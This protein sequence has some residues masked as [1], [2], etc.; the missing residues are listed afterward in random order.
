MSFL[1]PLLLA[2]LPLCGLPILIHLINQRRFQTVEWGAM[3]FLLEANRMAR[4]H[5]RIRRWL[6]LACRTLAI[7][8]LIFVISRPLAS[9]WIGLAGGS[10]SDTTI[11]LL[12]RSPSM[13]QR[14]ALAHASKLETGISQLSQAL[15][16]V[17]SKRWILIDSATL[18]SQELESPQMLSRT[19][20]ANAVSKSAH[21]PTLIQAAHDYIQENRSGQTEIWIL[22]DLQANDWDAENGRWKTLRDSFLQ[23]QQAVRFHLLAYPEAAAANVGVRVTSIERQQTGDTAQLLLSIILTA[24]PDAKSTEIPLRFDIQGVR[25]EHVVQ[26]EGPQLE[27]RN[28]AIPIDPELKQGHGRVTIP[29]DAYPTDDEYYFVFSEPMPRRAI[30]V[31]D[32]EDVPRP[33]RLA[34]A[35]SPDPNTFNEVEVVRPAQIAALNLGDVALLVWQAPL[36]QGGDATR[37]ESFVASGGQVIFLPPELPTADTLFG[38]GWTDWHETETSLAIENWRSDEDLLVRTQSGQS[39]PVGQLQIHRFCGLT[40][41]FTKLAWLKDGSPLLARVPTGKGGVWFLTT[42]IQPRDSSLAIDGVV[43]YAMLQ[44]AIANGAAARGNTQNVVAGILPKETTLNWKQLEGAGT[45]LSSDYADIAGVYSAGDRIVAINRSEQEDNPATLPLEKVDK[46]FE[47]LRFDRVS[48]SAGEFSALARE[49]WRIF[50]VL[51]IVVLF[52]ESLLCLPSRKKAT[53]SLP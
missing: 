3:R 40:G 34:T 17:R 51:L 11:I 49:I 35:I 27:L 1:E 6:I 37:I 16:L 45:L 53:T 26:W 43:L 32:E 36:P 25:T 2:A 46:L 18:A 21:L 24:S 52:V 15:G 48:D 50:L 38:I 20:A 30:L 4:G 14:D 39:L 47:G 29:A 23:F 7:A 10:E 13:N 9:G 31:A 5:S 41:E 22:S 44:R 33:L 8:A 12:D 19:V 28:F 42:T